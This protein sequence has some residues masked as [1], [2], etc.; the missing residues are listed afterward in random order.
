MGLNK[1][2]AGLTALSLLAVPAMAAP[3]P[4]KIDTAAFD[5]RKS[6]AKL[7]NGETLAYLELGNPQGPPVVLVHGYTDNARDWAP[8]TP[9][10]AKRFRLIVIDLRG[11]GQSSKPECCYT[12][13]DF[14]Y[15][16][17]LLL[18]QLKI[19]RADVVGHSL[20]S[21]VTQTF[22]EYWPERTGKVVLISST[23][24]REPGK[25]ASGGFDF[26]TPI[27]TLK[28]PID[29]NSAFMREWW[30]SPTPVDADF[31][32]RQREDSAR[33]PAHVWRA[34]IFQGLT[35]MELRSTLPMLKAPALLI[36]GGKD[37]IIGEAD[38]KSLT[39]GLPTAR[40]KLYP[41]LGHNPFWEEPE[42]VADEI[43]AFLAR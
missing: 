30:S 38:R 31:M 21:I 42:A 29:P 19:E 25:A 34:V 13:Q 22:A 26:V 5:G 9:Y 3:S 27:L 32:T 15:D 40:V 24:G 28:D 36:W 8:L 20:G 16:I 4:A 11:H 37:P 1:I 43:S 33:I 17:K 12:R 6:L 2:A 7:P 18:D 35:G 14:A 10:L 39:K 23:G 41:D